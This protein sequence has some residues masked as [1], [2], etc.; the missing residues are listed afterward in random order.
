M[1]NQWLL[2]EEEWWAHKWCTNQ[3]REGPLGPVCRD[4]VTWHGGMYSASCV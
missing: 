2:M 4:L 3:M 1:V